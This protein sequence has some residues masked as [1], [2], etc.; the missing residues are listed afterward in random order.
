[1]ASSS[2]ISVKLRLW[3]VCGCRYIANKSYR[4]KTNS[5]WG[6][7]NMFNIIK[8]PRNYFTRELLHDNNVAFHCNVSHWRPYWEVSCSE[9]VFCRPS[10]APVMWKMWASYWPTEE[11][12]VRTREECRDDD[13][14][15]LIG[16][17][18]ASATRNHQ[19]N[20]T[21]WDQQHRLAWT[22]MLHNT[23]V[24]LSSFH[25]ACHQIFHC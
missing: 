16:E 13:E 3:T 18:A 9:K 17:V 25:T 15:V 2:V 8:T 21:V 23:H 20:D 14:H 4:S 5:N 11:E 12:E 7:F 22:R 19:N 24:L 6:T 10:T 1:M